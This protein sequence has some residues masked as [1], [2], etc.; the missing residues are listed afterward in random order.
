MMGDITPSGPDSP[1]SP[2]RY[3]DPGP[4]SRCQHRAKEPNT[5]CRLGP[6]LA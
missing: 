2:T 5:R 4:A 3:K 6:G 1:G